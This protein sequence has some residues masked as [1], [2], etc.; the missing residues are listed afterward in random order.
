MGSSTADT[1][2][3]RK[4][5]WED[6]AALDFEVV[7]CDGLDCYLYEHGGLTAIGY[8]DRLKRSEWS[9]GVSRGL[10][11]AHG[12]GCVDFAQNLAFRLIEVCSPGRLG[13]I[14]MP[15]V[16]ATGLPVLRRLPGG[17]DVSL[18]LRRLRRFRCEEAEIVTTPD[19]SRIMV[20]MLPGE[21]DL[22]VATA[23]GL[24]FGLTDCRLKAIV[25]VRG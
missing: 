4:K 21:P 17:Q 7:Q 2:P 6:W 19:R 20:C 24:Y 22:W 13:E 15:A 18:E 25:C 10:E 14:A 11:L 5:L 1:G 9:Y 23:P 3:V 16:H 8:K 12:A